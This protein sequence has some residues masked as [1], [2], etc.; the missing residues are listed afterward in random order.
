LVSQ[1]RTPIT[2]ELT[3]LSVDLGDARLTFV[4]PAPAFADYSDEGKTVVR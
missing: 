3:L 2:A 1:D 4:A